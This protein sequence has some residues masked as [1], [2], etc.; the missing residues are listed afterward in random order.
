MPVTKYPLWHYLKWIVTPT[1]NQV[2]AICI[3]ASLAA[4]PTT[5]NNAITGTW[6]PALNNLAT[7]TYTFT[8]TAGLCAS[9]ATMTITV[10]PYPIVSVSSNTPICSGNT[11]V[12]NGSAGGSYSWTGPNGFTSN[13]QNPTIS[14]A[15]T[16]A[17]GTYQ[18]TVTSLG[19]SST[20]SV[21]VAVSQTPSIPVV[22][23][24]VAICAGTSTSVT[25]TTTPGSINWWSAPT[26]GTLLGTG[27]P[28]VVTPANTTTYYAEGTASGSGFIVTGISQ[29]ASNAIEIVNQTGDD[30]GGIAVT[31]G[32]VY[33]NGDQGVGRFDH[34]LNVQASLLPIRDGIFSDL[35]ASTSG[36]LWTL[37]NTITNSSP[38]GINNCTGCTGVVTAIRQMDQNMNLG[39]TIMLSVP[40]SLTNSP[41]NCCNTTSPGVFSGSGF[42]LLY[43]EISSSWFKIDLASGAVTTLGTAGGGGLNAGTTEN[44]ARWGWA[45]YDGTNYF[46]VYRQN[47][48]QS[49][50]KK[51]IGTG[52]VTTLTAFSNLGDMGNIIYS[53]W[54]NRV[55]M[56]HEIGAQFRNGDESLENPSATQTSGSGSGS[57]CVSVSRTAVTITVNPLPTATTTKVDV[58]CIGASTGSI[59]VNGSGGTA[60]Y[61]YSKDGGLTYQSGSNVFS[62]LA[63]G[64]YSI[65]IKDVNGCPNAA[66]TVTISQVDNI[67]PTISCPAPVTVQCASNVP[68]VNT[69]SVTAS[70]NC[71][72]V[73][74]F[75]SDVISNQTS[76]NK[77]TITRTYK[78]TDPSG[79]FVT[80]TQIIT[81]NDNIAPVFVNVG[82]TSNVPAGILANVPEA[83]QYSLLY[84][85]PIANSA[86]YSALSQVPYSVNNETSL[87][88]VAFNRI[89]YYME[90]DNKWVWV[91]MDKFTSTLNQIGLPAGVN[92]IWQQKVN[93]MNV[94]ASSNAGVTT[95]T[96]ITTG[97]IEIWNNCYTRGNA[98]NIPG[99][100]PNTYD[101]GDMIT[102][103]N[104][105]GSFQVH[106]YGALQTLFAYNRWAEGNTSDLGIGN[107]SGN[108][109]P[110]WTFM[111]NAPSY[112]TKNLYAFISG[113]PGIAA[114]TDPGQCFATVTVPTPTATDNCGTPTVAGVRSDNLALSATYP[115]GV[116][117]ITWTATDASNNSTTVTQTVT[118]KD[119]TP[120]SI[121]CPAPVTVQCASAVPAANIASVTATDNCSVTVSFVS[122]VISNQTAP[123]KYTIT[124]TYRATDPS[125]NST[126]CTQIIT[127]NDN[128]APV[129][130]C[131]SN[132]TIFATSAAGQ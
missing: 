99:A 46:A 126:T 63:V 84:K 56:H 24:S 70:D 43:S 97:N 10:N 33:I 123:N 34:N 128:T 79:N 86:L 20:S 48:I 87:A 27:S 89:A 5:S 101:F 49:I 118:V 113:S 102:N 106:N 58:V 35:N 40:I 39:T 45:E 83:S 110:D 77:Y 105:Y 37:W 69:A 131:P 61:Q 59:T 93:N 88:G 68:A 125:G 71:S 6:S 130:V 109:H 81:V 8:P 30:R 129:I 21:T 26:G 53:P 80:C 31:Q 22:S 116:T 107:N 127:V 3:G 28:F 52:V 9:Q 78:A 17:T 38:G 25:A 12:L 67:A 7:T 98:A 4:L 104:C 82:G 60:P 95:G 29:T 16:A 18:L 100:D 73:V 72:V 114:N 47:G 23:P 85:L 74:S 117:T 75:V 124:R 111:S 1:F 15:S 57:N 65:F 76:P 90:L 36:Q 13:I 62:G 54:D 55:F 122:D 91:S 41:N 92:V 112:G 132:Q 119:I 120:P 51:N 50:V 94:V 115:I 103:P 121:T 44:W 108:I 42:V 14:N 96:G 64:S 19:C 11:L 32:S 66:G 2:S